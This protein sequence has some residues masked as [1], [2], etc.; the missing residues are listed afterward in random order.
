MDNYG[1][2]PKGDPVSLA[3]DTR[4]QRRRA[5]ERSLTAMTGRSQRDVE[6]AYASLCRPSYEAKVEERAE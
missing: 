2:G 3:N 6:V 4:I 5:L 1:T